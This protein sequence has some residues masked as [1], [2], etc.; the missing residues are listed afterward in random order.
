MAF[1]SESETNPHTTIVVL[2]FLGREESL[3][4]RVTDGVTRSCAIVSK[5]ISYLSYSQADL[6]TCCVHI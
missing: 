4:R 3:Y 5:S 2:M 1:S 6:C